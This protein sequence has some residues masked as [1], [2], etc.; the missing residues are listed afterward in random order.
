MEEVNRMLDHEPRPVMNAKNGGTNPIYPKSTGPTNFFVDNLRIP[1]YIT[2]MARPALPRPTDSE[3]AILHVLWR[4]GPSTVRE[5]LDDLKRHR[6]MGYTTVLKIL[7]IMADKNLVARDETERTHVYRA[8]AT[9]EQTQSLLVKD[10]LNR[11]FD[12]SAARLVMQA[13][14]S[15]DASAQ[16]LAQI[17]KL[18]EEHKVQTYDTDP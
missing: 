7:Q 3:L 11:A 2:L 5:V 1:S 16:E 10:L 12:G 18:L 9:Q 17:R 15:G 8:S 14:A 4:R 6:E 13:L